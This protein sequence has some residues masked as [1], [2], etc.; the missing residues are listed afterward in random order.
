MRAFDVVAPGGPEVLTLVE[1]EPP[2]IRT[3][4]VLIRTAAVAMNYSDV[5]QRRGTYRLRPEAVQRLGLEC[6]GTITAVGVDVHHFKVGDEVCALVP[7]G[8]Y[9]ELVSVDARLVLPVPPSIALQDAASLPEMAAT[10][11]SNLIDIGRLREGSTVLVHGGSGGIG[12][13]AIQVARAFGARVF[14]TCGTD[15]KKARCLSLG[16]YL[17]INY[18]THDFVEE[19]LRETRGTGAD[20]ILDNMGG[21][22]LERNIQVAAEDGR[23]LTIGLQGGAR[24]EVNLGAMMEKRLALHVT[25]LRDRS[26]RERARILTGVRDDIWPLIERGELRPVIGRRFPFDNAVDAHRYAESGD[27]SGKTLLTL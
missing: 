15:K 19:I 22:Y 13:G 3:S 11:W 1:E 27:A 20:I 4:E 16:A 12:S 5:L 9:A 2:T 14:T 23:I 7:G 10:V 18:K 6:A 8:A 21:T 26:L 24:T 17:A 25:S